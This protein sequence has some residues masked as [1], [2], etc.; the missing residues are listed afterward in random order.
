MK[1]IIPISI[2]VSLC[3]LIFMLNFTTPA[4]AGP[5]G[6]LIIFIFA[7]IFFTGVIT[8]LIFFLFKLLSH[9]SRVFIVSNPIDSMGFRRS[10]LFSTV[11]ATAPIIAIGLQSVGAGSVYSYILILLFIIIGCLYISKRIH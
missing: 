5:F 1:K 8:Y 6:I 7:Y 9:L 3:L 2:F 10:Y 4:K 11:I